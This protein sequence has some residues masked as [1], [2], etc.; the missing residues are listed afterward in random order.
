MADTLVGVMSPCLAVVPMADL[1]TWLIFGGGMSPW[2]TFNV[3]PHDL[4]WGFVPVKRAAPLDLQ[5][6]VPNLQ[7][8]GCPTNWA[9]PQTSAGPHLPPPSRSSNLPTTPPPPQNPHYPHYHHQISI[10]TMSIPSERPK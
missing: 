6:G 5:W 7:W 10:S 8:G 9:C 1:S 3:C 2:L 4:R